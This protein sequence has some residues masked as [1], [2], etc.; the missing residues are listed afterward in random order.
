MNRSNDVIEWLTE[1]NDIFFE[2]S[3]ETQGEDVFEWLTSPGAS[4]REAPAAE[5]GGCCTE[6]ASTE[7]VEVLS[8]EEAFAEAISYRRKDVRCLTAAEETALLAAMTTLADNGTWGRFVD[9]HGRQG[10]GI[11]GTLGP[12]AG[13][14]RVH[15]S[16]TGGGRD[17]ADPVVN[18]ARE[19]AM[20]RFLPWHRL[21]LLEFEDELRAIDPSVVLPYWAFSEQRSVPGLVTRGPTVIKGTSSGDLTITRAPGAIADPL[22]STGD[23]EAVMAQT[24]FR[25]FTEA[26]ERIHN[27]GHDWVGGTMA[28]VT[29]S[30][31]DPIFWMLHAEIDRIWTRWT[32]SKVG[33]AARVNKQ[34]RPVVTEGSQEMPGIL[35]A[36]RKG[37]VPPLIVT[38]R[39][40]N[41]G[42]GYDRLEDPV[43]KTCTRP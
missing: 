6:G 40:L 38:T 26:L 2:Q 19:N 24:T 18:H 36:R 43:G 35:F 41:L 8:R 30:P 12:G 34:N 5:H 13:T 16:R 33:E 9:R 42:Y 1:S 37:E 23:V 39:A 29:I 10:A 11:H 21:F 25:S 20:N 27:T 4:L 28:T 32:N 31:A 22:P 17:P 3:G 14:G 15:R 7:G